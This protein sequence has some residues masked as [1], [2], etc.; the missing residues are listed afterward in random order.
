M[1]P[2]PIGLSEGEQAD[3]KVAWDVAMQLAPTHPSAAQ[4]ARR[5]ASAAGTSQSWASDFLANEA[6]KDTV[7]VLADHA[8]TDDND[9]DDDDDDV[10]TSQE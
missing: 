5:I 9:D 10:V 8:K 1:E 2:P 7:T 3:H 6:L 4:E